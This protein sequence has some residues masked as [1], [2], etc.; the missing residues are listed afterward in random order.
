MSFANGRVITRWYGMRCASALPRNRISNGPKRNSGLLSRSTPRVTM[1]VR[2]L[3]EGSP[4]LSCP[5]YTL[6]ECGGQS[7]PPA[8]NSGGHSDPSRRLTRRSWADP[9]WPPLP[10]HRAPRSPSA[11]SRTSNLRP[12]R[13]VEGSQTR[14]TRRK[15]SGGAF[16][17]APV[18][19]PQAAR[20]EFGV[21]RAFLATRSPM[22]HD[23]I[24]PTNGFRLVGGLDQ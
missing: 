3:G 10:G 22:L 5:E 21:R 2:L 23:E 18:V 13:P 24:I 12:C 17:A 11:R 15:S 19:R 8:F 6:Q 1:V 14:P 20:K 7:L 16:A 4:T 9:C